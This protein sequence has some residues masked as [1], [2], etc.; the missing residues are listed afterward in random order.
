[1]ASLSHEMSQ[2]TKESEENILDRCIVVI[3]FCI[4][5]KRELSQIMDSMRL[6]L[7]GQA[8]QR[9][10]GPANAALLPERFFSHP[11]LKRLLEDGMAKISSVNDFKIGHGLLVL[12]Y[13][14]FLFWSL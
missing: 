1:M 14:S 12:P 10:C 6:P 8:N 11:N 2:S 13:C 4:F 7:D 3:S 5:F 9:Y